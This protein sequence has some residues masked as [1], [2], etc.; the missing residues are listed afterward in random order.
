MGL[1]R[2]QIE[3]EQSVAPRR[4]GRIVE[5]AEAL[6][7]EERQEFLDALADMSIKAIAIVRVIRRRG[8]KLDENHVSKYRRELRESV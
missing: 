7:P 4:R 3:S 5:I 8:F 2:E 1:L 6:E